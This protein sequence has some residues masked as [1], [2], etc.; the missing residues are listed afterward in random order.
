MDSGS[1]EVIF[2]NSVNFFFIF[3]CFLVSL[4]W[5]RVVVMTEMRVGDDWNRKQ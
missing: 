4:G 1:C 3:L 2:G 5:V